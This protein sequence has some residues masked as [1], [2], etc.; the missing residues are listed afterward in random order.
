MF[1]EAYNR[2]L[3]DAAASGDTLSPALQQHLASCASCR[4]AFA[5]EQ[6]LFAA[7]DLGLS[8]TVNSEVPATLVSR[9]RVALNNEPAPQRHSFNFFAWG[10][11]GAAV[12]VAGILVLLYL[13]HKPTPLGLTQP[14]AVA[15]AQGPTG[16]PTLNPARAGDVSPLQHKKLVVLAASQNAKP[17]PP[18]VLVPPDEGATL[19]RYEEFLRR[20]QAVIFLASARSVDL[21]QGIEPLRIPEIEFVD[22]NIPPLSKWDSEGDTK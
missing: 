20:K 15:T 12:A 2:S 11:A 5:E 13:P 18:E 6:A 22:L 16:T 9:V 3:K 1:C 21:P 7:I 19:L 4:G 10:F 8:S 17:E 14:A